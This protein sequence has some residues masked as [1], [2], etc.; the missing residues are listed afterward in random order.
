MSDPAIP[1]A[2]DVIEPTRFY[3]IINLARLFNVPCHA[4]EGALDP[5]PRGAE[6][7]NAIRFGKLDWNRVTHDSLEMFHTFNP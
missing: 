1:S 4:V 2:G 6:I 5:Q 7:L 3:E